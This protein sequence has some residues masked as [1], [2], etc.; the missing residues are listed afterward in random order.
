MGQG[1][2]AAS[3]AGSVGGLLSACAASPKPNRDPIFAGKGFLALDPSAED[4]LRVARGLEFRIVAMA[5]DALSAGATFGYNNDYIQFFPLDAKPGEGLLCVNHE[6][7]GYV[8]TSGAVQ[9]DE[10]KTRAQV[11]IERGLV[12]VS[13]LHI[14]EHAKGDWR[15]LRGSKY[16]RRIDGRT[17]IP[18]VSGGEAVGTVCNCAGGRT[19]WGTYLTCEENYQEFYGET[20]I[21]N[22]KRTHKS[23]K[24]FNW[25]K[26]FPEPPEHYG[27]VVE[28]EPKTGAA[29]KLTAMGRFVHECAT[30][31]E[32]V[33]G[34]CVAYMGDDS[35]GEHLYKFIADKPRSLETGK[36]YV[37]DTMRGLWLPLS[38]NE[39]YRLKR[40]FQDHTELLIRAREAA[41]IVGATPLDRP[42]DIEICP[43]TGAVFVTLTNSKQRMNFYGSIL[44]VEEKNDDPFSL[45]FTASTFL[46]GGSDTGFAC[47]DNM[48]FDARGNL[49]LTTDMPGQYMNKYP[50]EAFKNNGLF[51]IPMD[52][53][54]AGRASLV[55][56]GPTDSELTGP[57][58]SPDGRTLF[59]S[60]QHPGE[61]SPSVDHPTSRWP[62]GGVPK[63]AVVAISGE[64]LDTIVG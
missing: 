22:G 55:A 53:P 50:Y 6:T 23:S 11:E 32:G 43:R 42:E 52:G 63:P 2:A 7:P 4:A 25:D 3:L 45:E 10:K 8:L 1:A 60:V 5:G 17:R 40:R 56:T 21:L 31:R 34:R 41:K 16:N 48:V 18:L 46:A 37:A 61:Y 38:R 13:I 44:K 36:L 15:L 9:N 35:E 64:L 59:L 28:I 49:W 58:F 27:W 54:N 26:E 30:V 20:V 29:K 57:C 19:P 33:G 12:G 39:D 62:D 24:N 51:F 47:P 14:R